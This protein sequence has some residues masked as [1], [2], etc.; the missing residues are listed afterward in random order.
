MNIKIINNSNNP[1]PEY[2]SYSAAGFDI[3]AFI[4]NS[5]NITSIGPNEHALIKT[6]LHMN[7]PEGYE[8]QIRPR[9]GLAFKNKI[10]VLNSPGTID[11]DYTGE[12]GIILINHSD[13]YFHVRNGDRVAQGVLNKVPQCTFEEVST[14][15]E[16]VRGKKGFGSTG[17]N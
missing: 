13:T 8:L 11:A 14:L 17:V 10:T 7:I 5:D 2:E 12:I 6:G 15:A 9:S 3:R 1:L 16:T 4:D